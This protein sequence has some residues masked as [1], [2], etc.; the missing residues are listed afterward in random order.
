MLT[1]RASRAPARVVAQTREARNHGGGAAAQRR[2]GHGDGNGRGAGAALGG[3]QQPLHRGRRRLERRRRV[4]RQRIEGAAAL[5]AVG[6]PRA[7]RLSRDPSGDDRRRHGRR[8][9]HDGPRAGAD[10]DCD[11]ELA[12][13]RCAPQSITRLSEVLT[14]AA[15]KRD[16]RLRCRG[17]RA[18]STSSRSS[19]S[20]GRH[21]PIVANVHFR[22]DG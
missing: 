15:P 13:L 16:G 20:A 1:E 6:H 9:D 12:R 10:R 3:G 7:G 21:Q 18:V 2:D 4:L 14:R 17:R 22:S 11:R 5:A 8:L 19:S